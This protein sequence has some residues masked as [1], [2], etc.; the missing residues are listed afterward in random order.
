MLKPWYRQL[1]N[2]DGI[3]HKPSNMCKSW[4]IVLL[5]A[6]SAI[7]CYP[8]LL[9]HETDMVASVLLRS[10]L[11]GMLLLYVP[12]LLRAILYTTTKIVT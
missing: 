2:V 6:F 10:T 12:W 4:P 7:A 11:L 3:K 8:Q 9:K 1:I 5:L